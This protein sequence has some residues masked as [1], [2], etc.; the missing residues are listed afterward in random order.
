MPASANRSVDARS[1]TCCWRRCPNAERYDDAIEH[2]GASIERTS[3]KQTRLWRMMYRAWYIQLRDG[4]A[5]GIE[6]YREVEQTRQALGVNIEKMKT[7]LADKIREAEERL[8][9]PGE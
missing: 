1:D 6:A 5:A 2:V 8:R 7:R 9:A 4:D 3:D